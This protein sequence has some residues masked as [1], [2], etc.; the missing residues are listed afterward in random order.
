LFEYEE[1]RNAVSVVIPAHNE[2]TNLEPLISGL[3]QLYGDYIVELVIV[4]DNSTDRTGGLL[5]EMRLKEPRIRP[6]HR[7]PPNGVGRAIADG[8]RAA[9]G[10]YVLTM[11]CDF[12]QLLPE[13]RDLFEAAAQGNDVIV[14]SRFSRHSV[15]LNYPFMKIL[16][17]RTF[18]GLARI[19]LGYNF[20]DVTN[21]LK[22]VKREVVESLLLR[23]PGFSVNAETGLQPYLLGYRI[24]E[25]PISWINRTP[26]MGT[27]SFRLVKVG[28]GYWT[29]LWGLWLKRVFNRGPYRALVRQST[30]LNRQS[31][32][33]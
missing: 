28:G 12:Q 25:V 8:L 23:Q 5:E 9:R 16:A 4:N 10:K 21:N 13:L 18:H 32:G 19:V 29:V 15:L 20:R 33:G 6:I 2:E 30:E 27:S 26:G 11:D 24:R 3:L 14:G 1:L 31:I 22:L 17:N 7:K